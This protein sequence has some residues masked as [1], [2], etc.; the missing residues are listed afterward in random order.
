MQP[1]TLKRGAD[2]TRD[3]NVILEFKRDFYCDK[4]DLTCA[5]LKIYSDFRFAAYINGAFVSNAQFADCASVKTYTEVE[6]SAFLRCGNNRIRVIILHYDKDY[7]IIHATPRAFCAFEI[8]SGD[9]ILA[10]SDL[11]TAARVS[12]RYKIGDKITPQL[13]FCFDYDF[14]AGACGAENGESCED[15]ENCENCENGK[16]SG[17]LQAC[18][19]EEWGEVE[20]VNSSFE[21][22]KRPISECDVLPPAKSEI[23]A[24]GAFKYNGGKSAG[25]KMQRAYLSNIS[26]FALS[27]GK[28][29]VKGDCVLSGCD[30]LKSGCARQGG[31]CGFGSPSDASASGGI[32]LSFDNAR[33]FLG[34]DLP[35]GMYVLADLGRE[36]C[37]YL[38]ICVE[39]E[40]DCV[41]MLG[42][43]EHL[44]DLRLRT[45]VGGRN[46]GLTLKLKKGKNT[47]DDRLLR[48]GLRYLCLFVEAQSV[49]IIRLSVS[50]TLYP[51]KPVKKDFGDKLL[52]KIY[53]TGART[54]LLCAHEHYEDCPWR[55]QALY[56]MDS[57]NQMLF[58]YGAFEKEQA[59]RFA[60]ASLKLFAQCLRAD[61]LVELCP[62]SHC[63]LVIPSFTFYWIIAVCEN[64]D[65]DLD[66]AFIGEILPAVKLAADKFL[67]RADERGLKT[68]V[69][70]DY[71]NFHEWSDGLDGFGHNAS[72]SA[73]GDENAEADKE[74]APDYDCILTAL[75]VIATK[76]LSVLLKRIGKVGEG[77]RYAAH[78]A[79][80]KRALN[81]FFDEKSGFYCSYL[82]K[83]GQKIGYH[84]YTQAVVLASGAADNLGETVE[85]RLVNAL[86][87]GSPALVKMTYSAMLI[88]YEA[89]IAADKNADWCVENVADVF[90][91]MLLGG[92][93]SYYE[94]ALGE[95]DFDDAGSLC[96][97]WS[98]AACYVL[99]TYAA[100]KSKKR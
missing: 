62:P 72:S 61:G 21:E 35:S 77:E 68:L 28:S 88:K 86:K 52:N 71:W 8:T 6:I 3:S 16:N 48:F 53:E 30:N 17:A 94:T 34:D 13:G 41:A 40:N 78:S 92:A 22:Q 54:L 1:I 67:S 79:M 7:Q 69:G 58:G 42:W 19:K 29:R 23:I 70:S 39:V 93:T 47:L 95:R 15:C 80:L 65:F 9:K 37:G 60:R 83:N 32:F 90:G 38:S 43:G 5:K 74:P 66:L 46:F 97:G 56:G 33:E 84:E 96:H 57:R 44:A 26:F 27:G 36:T 75:A 59:L 100:L 81:G 73:A 55:E 82:T 11:K 10:E 85:S 24:Q 25:E 2:F 99:D 45:S 64:A 63:D 87:N 18:A 91:S 12:P 31:T 51:F 4:Q 50:E 20:F 49:K 76:R 98:A 14:T 89:I